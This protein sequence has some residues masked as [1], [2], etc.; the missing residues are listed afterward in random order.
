MGDDNR[1]DGIFTATNPNFEATL[2][3]DA[4]IKLR[5]DKWSNSLLRDLGQIGGTKSWIMAD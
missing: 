3:D 4:K 2:C 1:I 5:L